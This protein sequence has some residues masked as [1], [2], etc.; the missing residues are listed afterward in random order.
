MS[1]ILEGEVFAWVTSDSHIGPHNIQD[2]HSPERFHYTNSDMTDYGWTKVG[3]AD[4]RLE[5]F[6]ADEW[7]LSKID[8][9]NAQIKR[10]EAEAEAKITE[11]KGQIQQLLAITHQPTD[12]N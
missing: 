4:I 7:V 3:V 2:I 10:T 6:D 12:E 11:L 9:L 8:A 1:K 5:L